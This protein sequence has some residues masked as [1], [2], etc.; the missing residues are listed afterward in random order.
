MSLHKIYKYFLT[1]IAVAVVIVTTGA[2]PARSETGPGTDGQNENRDF[3]PGRILVKPEERA[4]A[5]AIGSL[6]RKNDARTEEKLPGIGVSVIDLPKDL[7]VTEAVKR[8]ENAPGIEYAE[9]DYLL[10]SDAIP[11]DPRFGGLYGLNNTGQTG[12]KADA[13]IDAPEAWDI[14]TGNAGTVVAVIDS[15]VDVDHPDL[16]DNIWT[17]PDEIPG[18]GI[19][20]DGNG[21]VDDVNGWDFANNDNSLYHSYAED[22]HG[23]HVA[24]TIGAA[25]NNG[26]GISGVAWRAKIMPLKFIGP[27]GTGYTSNAAKALDYAIAEGVKISNN[28]YGCAGCFSSSLRDTIQRADA[29]GH[30]FVASAGNAG[31]DNDATAHY[32]SGHDLP[33][34]ISVAA[35]DSGDALA[36]FSNYGNSSVDLAAPGVGILSTVPDNGYTSYSGTSMA[37]PHVAGVAALVKSR[38]PELDGAGVKARILGSVDKKASLTGKTATGGRLNAASA[39]GATTT[40][41]AKPAPDTME[42]II[43]SVRPVSGSKTRDRTPAIRAVI[44]DNKTNLVKSN[45]R[46]YVDG[47]KIGAFAYNASTDR[48]AYTSGRLSYARHTIKLVARDA[49]G[50]T[51]TVISRFIVAR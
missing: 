17:N 6:N 2:Q 28:S 11:N 48:L 45:I 25:G 23:T 12:G 15:G 20:D 22:D 18:N 33:N 5:G 31:A 47:R 51:R 32:P 39:L 34:I 43:K 44:R 13:D 41:T 4:P 16:R 19:D 46:L 10:R 42:P 30:L 1:T 3:A 40:V 9:P 24:G 36:G 21:Y 37:S 35:T 8:Y 27:N 14:T 38:S 7:P 50:N 26:V 49:S 29:A